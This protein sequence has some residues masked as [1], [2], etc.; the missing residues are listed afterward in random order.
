[1]PQPLLATALRSTMPK[2]PLYKLQSK[3]I[4]HSYNVPPPYDMV[5]WPTTQNNDITY[6]KGKSHTH[7]LK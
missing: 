2:L 3:L 6:C 4:W 5:Q 1:M 7:V